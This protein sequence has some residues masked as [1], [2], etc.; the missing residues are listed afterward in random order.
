MTQR[1]SAPRVRLAT[2]GTTG[3][4]SP[5]DDPPA[6]GEVRAALEVTLAEMGRMGRIET[7]DAARVQLLRLQADQL[8]TTSRKNSQMHREF[9]EA[10]GDL[11]ADGDDGSNLDELLAELR[12][13]VRDTP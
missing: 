1:T 3:P 13:E 6:S 8:D 9:R 11:L 12:A 5:S 10:L 2:A 4:K 7:I